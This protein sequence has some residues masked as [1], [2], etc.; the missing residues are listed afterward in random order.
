MLSL[1]YENEFSFILKLE[2]IIITKFSHF[3]RENEGNSE[4]ALDVDYLIQSIKATFI[5]STEQ[6]KERENKSIVWESC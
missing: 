5:A 4:I 6:R 1:C 3:E 2:L